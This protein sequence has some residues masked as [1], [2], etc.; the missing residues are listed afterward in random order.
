MTMIVQ[1]D[2]CSRSKSQDLN[3]KS[4]AD[5]K[6]SFGTKYKKKISGRNRVHEVWNKSM[7]N[8]WLRVEKR[9]LTVAWAETYTRWHGKALS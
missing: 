7:L 1:E 9:K 6:P 3:R 5:G 2:V 4:C 8:E